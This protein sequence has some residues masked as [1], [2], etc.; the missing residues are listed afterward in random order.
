MTSLTSLVVVQ[1]DNSASQENATSKTTII[2]PRMGL[3][4]PPRNTW[5]KSCTTM[6]CVSP[7]GKTV[8]NP[9]NT[10]Y[11]L[12]A[13]MTVVSASPWNTEPK[14]PPCKTV[15]SAPP[16]N[17]G[18]KSPAGKTVVTKSRIVWRMMRIFT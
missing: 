7:A 9:R 2:D 5:L 1:P 3:P 6:Y 12:P 4:R 13:G 18:R 15:V 8:R 16:R 11:K 17:T 14:S 10:G